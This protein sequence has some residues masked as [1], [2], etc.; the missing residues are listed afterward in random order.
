MRFKSHH[1]R[2]P[3]CESETILEWCVWIKMWNLEKKNFLSTWMRPQWIVSQLN[4]KFIK[5]SVFRCTFEYVHS[6]EQPRTNEW[7]SERARKRAKERCLEIW[8]FIAV[9][10]LLKLHTENLDF[11]KEQNVYG[12]IKYRA[13]KIWHS[14]QTVRFFLFMLLLL[15]LMLSY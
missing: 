7:G 11:D 13:F 4:R 3:M 15:L 1:I 2:L 5:S 12:L 10:H 14:I 6:V 9:P 8:S